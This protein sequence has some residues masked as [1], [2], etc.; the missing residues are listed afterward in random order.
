MRVR[1]RSTV[2]RRY[3]R[4]SYRFKPARMIRSVSVRS[5]FPQTYRTKM[6]WATTAVSTASAYS[7]IEFRGNGIYDPVVAVGGDQPKYF[8]T[9]ATVYSQWR[10]FASKIVIRAFPSSASASNIAMM[11]IRPKKS[12]ISQPSGL[13]Y[14]LRNQYTKTRTIPITTQPLGTA[15]VHYATSKNILSKRDIRDDSTST[16]GVSGD[17]TNQWY[18]ELVVGTTDEATTTTIRFIV[19]I[20]YYV[21]WFSPILNED[22]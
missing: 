19:K 1:G 12:N 2:A 20:Y 4:K 7:Y 9:L 16:G 3:R 15:L 8:D 11:I 22:N 17:P 18:W 6:T 5:T 13:Y 14:A 21:E 10:V